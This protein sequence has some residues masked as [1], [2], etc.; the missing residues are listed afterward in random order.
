MNEQ[1]L[2]EESDKEQ[3]RT[4]A[5]IGLGYVG[6]PLALLFAEKGYTVLGIDNDAAKIAMLQR[7]KSY[8]HEIDAGEVKAAI[9]AGRLLPNGQMSSLQ[10]AEAVIPA[11]GAA[12]GAG[13]LHVSGNNPRG[14]A[15]FAFADRL[16]RWQGS[17]GCLFPG[18]SGSRQ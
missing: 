17:D 14:A 3:G 13:K 4:V 12:P 15:A 18:E 10:A 9:D 2:V 8:I 1:R 16:F 6:L 5:I 11:Q 7:G